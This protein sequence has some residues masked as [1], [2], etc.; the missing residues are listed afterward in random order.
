[1]PRHA[2]LWHVTVQHLAFLLPCLPTRVSSCCFKPV[3]QLACRSACLCLHSYLQT[4]S[5]RWMPA[6]KTCKADP[7]LVHTY[8]PVAH[9]LS[10]LLRSKVL[11][12]GIFSVGHT[13]QCW[14]S[15][16]SAPRGSSY[17]GRVAWVVCGGLGDFW[18][19]RDSGAMGWEASW[20]GAFAASK[21]VCGVVRGGG[22][23]WGGTV[24][25]ASGFAAVLSA[26]SRA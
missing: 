18:S 1:M 5:L 21:S 25:C 8:T 26:W 14:I 22:W 16:G 13:D 19:E 2:S 3:H 24:E 4:C 10:R 9:S 11:L 17:V 15:A 20:L 6:T 12:T 23:Q 7:L